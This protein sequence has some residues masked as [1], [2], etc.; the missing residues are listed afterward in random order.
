LN[1]LLAKQ[2]RKEKPVALERFLS[3]S[4]YTINPTMKYFPLIL[5]LATAFVVSSCRDKEMTEDEIRQIGMSPCRSSAPFIKTLGFDPTRSSL[6]TDAPGMMGVVLVE[7]PRKVADSA[8]QRTYQ[9]AS[10]SKNGWMGNTTT[11]IDGNIY[12]APLPKAH[13]IGIPLSQMNKVFRIESE[14]GQME[15]LTELP[16]PDSAAVVVPFAVLGIYYDCHGK[17]L[18]VSSVAGSTKDK[19]NGVIYVI[20]PKDGDIEDRLEGH[21]AASV[22]V[23]GITGEKRLY[24]GGLHSSDIYS[25]ALTRNGNF[26]GEVR[27]EGNLKHAG[28]PNNIRARSLRFD[29]NGNLLVSG[30]PFNFSVSDARIK[31]ETSYQFSYDR[32]KKKWTLVDG[33]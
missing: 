29:E 22:F 3:G 31:S 21:D 27:S 23:G 6:S 24:F 10:W 19:E 11:D 9:D 32:N 8:S 26:K 18:Y 4:F 15:V 25:I 2:K 13:E 12:T 17:K 14:T 1:F 33:G 7:H 20:D 28:T 30:S 5:L 16:T